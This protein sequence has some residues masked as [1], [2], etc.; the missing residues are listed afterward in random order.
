MSEHDDSAGPVPLR[1]DA[2][3]AFG[4]HLDRRVR[5]SVLLRADWP[6]PPGVR[7]FTTLRR[8]LNVGV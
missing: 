6:A 1:G 4:R 3:T 8:G 5:E 2:A 7:A